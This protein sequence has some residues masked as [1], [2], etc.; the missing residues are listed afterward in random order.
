MRTLLG[1]DVAAGVNVTDLVAG[2][3]SAI[4]VEVLWRLSGQLAYIHTEQAGNAGGDLTMQD[5]VYPDR[6]DNA[7]INP[8]KGFHYFTGPELRISARTKSK[9]AVVDPTTTG[10]ETTG[11][12]GATGTSQ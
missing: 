4:D 5:A 1:F 12:T 6:Y 10:T 8:T 7:T 11:T 3:K 2:G 9:A